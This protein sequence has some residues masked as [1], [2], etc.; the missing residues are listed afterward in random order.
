MAGRPT[1][2]PLSARWP[3]PSPLEWPI[4]AALRL[5]ALRTVA[6][7]GPYG[8]RERSDDEQDPDE[9]EAGRVVSLAVHGGGDADAGDGERGGKDG[10]VGLHE[11]SSHAV[12]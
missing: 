2:P 11:V 10:E 1:G 4:V 12:C 8:E 7:G 3:L 5:L 9:R 6:L